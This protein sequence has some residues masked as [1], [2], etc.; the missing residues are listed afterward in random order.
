MSE[1]IA[2]FAGVS[3]QHLGEGAS[4]DSIRPPLPV[5]DVQGAQAGFWQVREGASRGGAEREAQ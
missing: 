3:V 2:D 5:T 4:Q 1:V